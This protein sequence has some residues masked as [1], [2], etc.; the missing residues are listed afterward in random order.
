MSEYVE[1]LVLTG[2]KV[3]STDGG[4]GTGQI[5]VEADA[6]LGSGVVLLQDHIDYSVVAA[7]AAALNL[8]AG[9]PQERT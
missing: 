9:T 2:A 6:D 5:V 7:Q 4:F 1:M 8:A 3:V